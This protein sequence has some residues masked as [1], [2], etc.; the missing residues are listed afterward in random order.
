MI[1][2]VTMCVFNKNAECVLRNMNTCEIM[3]VLK[4]GDDDRPIMR[5]P[6]CNRDTTDLMECGFSFCPYCGRR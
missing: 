1:C 2:G 5:C 6:S 4:Y 3:G